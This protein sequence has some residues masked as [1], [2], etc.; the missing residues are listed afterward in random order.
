MTTLQPQLK[1]YRDR[2][3]RAIEHDLDRGARRRRRVRATA[4]ATALLAIIA[5]LAVANLGTGGPGL[6]PAEAAILRSA[7][8]ALTPPAGTILHVQAQVTVAGQGTQPYELWAQADSPD[9]YRV[10]KFGHEDAWTGTQY[11]SYDPA[12][13]TI[14]T[15]P[16]GTERGSVDIAASLRALLQ[17]GQARVEGQTTVDGVAAYQITVSGQGPGWLS[18]VANGAYDVAQ[19]D[20]HPLLV[21]TEVDCGGSACAETVRFQTY[22]YLPATSANLA[23]LDL[24]AQHPGARSVAGTS[25][26]DSIFKSTSR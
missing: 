11:G 8:H 25:S 18:G 5:G 23:L 12:T 17:S 26:G 19:S 13:N 2:L 6:R 4:W 3:H 20:E 7:A 15:Y 16:G 21:Q 10:I 1:G 9:A 24:S 22:E 14:T